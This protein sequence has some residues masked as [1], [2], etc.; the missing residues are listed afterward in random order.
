M[1]IFLSQSL[2][3]RGNWVT[4]KSVQVGIAVTSRKCTVIFG[5]IRVLWQILII[6]SLTSGNWQ[7]FLRAPLLWQ[8]SLALAAAQQNCLGFYKTYQMPASN[9]VNSDVTGLVWSLGIRMFLKLQNLFGCAA[10]PQN[11]CCR[12]RV[13]IC[14]WR[15]QVLLN[16]GKGRY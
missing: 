8:W 10:R 11:H 2:I 12:I 1:R 14:R 3:R 9:Q 6:G 16:R 15:A 13:E 7:S 4:S 5:L